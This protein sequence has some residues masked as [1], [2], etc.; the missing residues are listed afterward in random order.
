M[1][2]WVELDR[3]MGGVKIRRPNL[4]NFAGEAVRDMIED[5][6]P[7]RWWWRWL[8]RASTGFRDPSAA[9]AEVGA[10]AAL[11]RVLLAFTRATAACASCCGEG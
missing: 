11:L 7:T 5:E 8:G 4:S 10:G 9:G 2:P 3:L 6:E 1:E